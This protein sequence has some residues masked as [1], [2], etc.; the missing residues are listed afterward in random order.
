MKMKIL[1]RGMLGFPIGISI[2]YI[3]TILISLFWG[4]GY[5]VPCVPELIAIM[6]N[7]IRAVILQTIL[8]GLLGT[9]FAAGSVVWEMETWSIVKQTGIYFLIASAALLPIAY[10]NRWMEHSI[11]GFFSYFGIFAAI[12]VG[13]W[14]VQYLINRHLVRKMNSKLN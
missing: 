12:F 14:L 13:I 3:I 10:I 4:Q 2:G 9:A 1:L 5:Y 11:T 7:E 6:G 8:C